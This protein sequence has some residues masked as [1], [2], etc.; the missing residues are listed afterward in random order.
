MKG[1]EWQ[2]K[3]EKPYAIRA[4]YH[5]PY[6]NQDNQNVPAYLLMFMYDPAPD[7]WAILGWEWFVWSG[8]LGHDGFVL[9][10]G[11]YYGGPSYYN[12][13]NLDLTQLEN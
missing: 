10:G 3:N 11:T 8:I 12:P 1:Y 7:Y 4:F 9:K 5:D 13:K 2:E 6:N